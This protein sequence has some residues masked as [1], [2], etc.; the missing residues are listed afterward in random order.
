MISR[1]Q[2]ISS[3]AIASGPAKIAWTEDNA[4]GLCAWQLAEGS[5]ALWNP[6]DTTLNWP[7]SGATP[8]NT[9]GDDEHVWNYSSVPEGILAFLW[10]LDSD[11]PGY[12]GIR[13]Q[14]ASGD[15][16]VALAAA[17]AASAWGTEPFTRTV[18]QVQ[19][20]PEIYLS[21]PLPNAA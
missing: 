6:W 16:P 14:L 7:G 8:Y 10:T 18:A 11:E 3:V 20:Y 9:F 12:A 4:I 13:A 1:G 19:A 21:E 2:F 5:R 15:N 17:V